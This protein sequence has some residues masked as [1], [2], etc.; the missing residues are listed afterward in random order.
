MGYLTDV[1]NRRFL[2]IFSTI[3]SLICAILILIYDDVNMDYGL[4]FLMY[5]FMIGIKLPAIILINEK[6]K[7]TQRLAVN[8]AF[9]KFCFIGSIFGVFCTG[10]VME[11]I[12]PFGLWISVIFVLFF[13]FYFSICNYC[14]KFFQKTLAFSGFFVK[15]NFIQDKL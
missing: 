2:I 3:A 1:I 10:A 12:G 6:Y 14:H 13:Y 15:N 7:P 8:A 4:L 5:G 11:V 9:S